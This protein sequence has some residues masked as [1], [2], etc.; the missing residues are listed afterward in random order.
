MFEQVFHGVHDS[1]MVGIAIRNEVNQSDKPIGLSFRRRDQMSGDVIWNLLEKV[2]QSNSR[3]NAFDILTIEVHAV[4]I[5]IGFGG[6]GIKTK[7]RT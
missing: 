7:G 6:D 4:K 5:P 1:D 2:L 3:F